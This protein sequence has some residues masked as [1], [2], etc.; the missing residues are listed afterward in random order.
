MSSTVLRP[1]PIIK[2]LHGAF[3]RDVS[4]QELLQTAATGIRDAG[5]PYAGVYMYMVR[6]DSL[7]LE[8][9][10]GH[11]TEVTSVPV[12]QAVK[13]DLVVMI[14]LHKEILGEIA[15]ESDLPDAFGEAEEDAVRQV[16]D[17]LAVLL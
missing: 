17:A 9:F 14:R 6:G 13:S 15:I 5:A 16:A 7:E 10:A 12:G 4:R 2:A 11:P 1:D 3:C 8:A